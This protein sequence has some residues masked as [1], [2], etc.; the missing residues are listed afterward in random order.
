MAKKMEH[1]EVLPEE[2]IQ[3]PK[4]VK[5]RTIALAQTASAHSNVIDN[6][7]GYSIWVKL[8]ANPDYS[9]YLIIR[10][11]KHGKS[12]VQKWINKAVLF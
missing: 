12:L 2:F 10:I 1:T 8:V 9:E 4:I 5:E 7:R 11:F 6:V 3:L